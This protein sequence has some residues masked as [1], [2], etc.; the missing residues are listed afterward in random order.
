MQVQHPG[1]H[2]LPISSRQVLMACSGREYPNAKRDLFLR[3]LGVPPSQLQLA[4][5]VHGAE[6]VIADPEEVTEPVEADGLIIG[7]SGTAIG[8]LT[9]DCIPVFFWDALQGVGGLAH[10]GWKGLKAGI[11]PKMIQ[12]L[13]AEFE[14]RPSTIQMA[15]GPAIRKC[16]YEVG[17]EF[18]GIFP[19]YYEKP[20]AGK[21]HVDLIAIAADQAAREGVPRP[22]I[23]DTGVCTSCQNKSFFSARKD[24]SPE[25]ILSVLQIK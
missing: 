21:A 11:I 6:I 7:S 23:L 25:R 15:F 12:M 3:D 19:E 18:Q 20:A 17:E 16:C 2:L 8:I 13:H 4:R 24:K 14:T 9:A 22:Q 10:A 1:I 5:Q